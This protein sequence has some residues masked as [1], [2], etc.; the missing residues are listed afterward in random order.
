[1]CSPASKAETNPEV[2]TMYSSTPALAA[3]TAAQLLTVYNLHAP[4]PVGRFESRAVGVKRLATLLAKIEVPTDDA[5]F[6]A[7]PEMKPAAPVA[8]VVK[9]APA[10]KAPGRARAAIIAACSRPEGATSVELY[11]ATTWRHCSWNH[12]LS[13]AAKATG[14]TATV[15]KVDGTTRYFLTDEPTAP[16]DD[17]NYVGSRH[18]Y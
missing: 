14:K 2:Y 3:L 12:H 13:V 9:A 5:V 16:M 6:A 18:H 10:E 15:R 17:F 4:Q 8:E 1:M 7:F 11:A